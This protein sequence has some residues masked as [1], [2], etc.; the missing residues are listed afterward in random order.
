MI[1]TCLVTPFRIALVPKETLRSQIV[2]YMIDIIFLLD[3]IVI[4]NT[5]F[6]DI[7]YVLIDKRSQIA[8]DYLTGWFTIDAFAIIPFD[9]IFGGN[10]MN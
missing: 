9:I 4:F 3:I 6:F 10:S 2:S 1:F 5:A 7:E 8:K